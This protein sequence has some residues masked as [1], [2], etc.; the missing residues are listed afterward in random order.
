MSI[1]I[2]DQQLVMNRIC[3]LL[4]E[5]GISLAEFARAMGV[6][7]SYVSNWKKRGIPVDRVP[8]AADVLG[9]SVDKLLG[10]EA[11]GPEGSQPILLS[12]RLPIVGEAQLGD[13][14]YFAE[15]SRSDVPEGY[16][17]IPSRDPNAFAVRCRG[18]SM[19]PRIQPGEYVVVEPSI[20]ASPGDEVLVEAMD[21]RVMVKRYLYKKAG[22][23]Y[24]GSVNEAHPNIV[25]SLDNVRRI[26]P[27][28]AI[29]QP[30]LL[31]IA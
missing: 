29:I 8:R 1:P 18:T 22:N 31:Q 11:D 2:N 24:L 5:R 13:N 17:P 12:G 27:V 4:R 9:I 14:G 10:R 20:E 16:L 28:L 15:F 19:M 23:V 7:S 25:I 3:C 30:K 6:L 26:S 21:G